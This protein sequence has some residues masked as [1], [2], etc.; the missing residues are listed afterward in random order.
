[1]KPVLYGSLAAWVSGVPCVVN[2]L[3][4]LGYVFVSRQIKARLLRPFIAAGFRLLLN[5]R[6]SCLIL[7]NSD[8]RSMMIQSQLAPEQ[9]IRLIRGSGVDT[10]L[11]HPRP[12]PQ[13]VPLVILASRMLWEKGVGEFVAAAGILK[14]RGVNARFVLVGESDGDN[15]NAIPGTTLGEW[16]SQGDVEWWRKR[17][18]MPEVMGLASIFCLPSAYG[19]GIPKVLLEAAASGL[20]IVTTDAPGCREVVRHGVNGL[21]VPVRCA[22]DLADA[23]HRLIESPSLRKSMGEQG[24]EIAVNE[25]SEFQVVAETMAVYEELLGR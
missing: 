17:D 1:M 15:P 25:F 10:D 18:D 8:D 14:K 24:R 6:N 7:Q 16:N 13:G 20:P 19:E 2:A 23:L 11:F 3:A 4:G 22:V 5:R 21:L 12:E 9:R